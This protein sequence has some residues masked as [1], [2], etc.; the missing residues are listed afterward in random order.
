MA[1]IEAAGR[2][3]LLEA[4]AVVEG[5][6]RMELAAGRIALVVGKLRRVERRTGVGAG[7]GK[8][9]DLLVHIRA[10]NLVVDIRVAGEGIVGHRELA[11]AGKHLLVAC[12]TAAEADNQ[13]QIA[14]LDRSPAAAVDSQA[15]SSADNQTDLVETRM[16]TT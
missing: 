4:F 13:R 7:V 1:R 14:D 5:T 12:H 15:L 8:R 6:G 10:S 16:M 9:A 11:E 3:L 2:H